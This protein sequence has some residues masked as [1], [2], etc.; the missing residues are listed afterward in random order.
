MVLLSNRTVVSMKAVFKQSETTGTKDRYCGGIH[1]VAPDDRLG[2][3]EMYKLLLETP[4]HPEGA[5]QPVDW[6]LL[7]SGL[8][9]PAPPAAQPAF[10]QVEARQAGHVWP[11]TIIRGPSQDFTIECAPDSNSQH[12]DRHGPACSA[13]LWKGHWTP[14]CARFNTLEC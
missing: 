9:A 14:V 5:G 8:S 3:A 4:H 1:K 2:A 10:A 13:R 12:T 6:D 7:F 11:S